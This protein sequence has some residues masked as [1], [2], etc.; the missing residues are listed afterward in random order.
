[1]A[2]NQR[3]TSIGGGIDAVTFEIMRNAFA[4]V[5]NEMA[6]VVAKT[7]YST[8]V[9]EGRDFSGTVYDADGGQ[10]SQGEFDLPAFVG[11]TQVTVPEV[12]KTMGIENIKPGDIYMVNDPFIASTHCN[13]VHMVKPVF[14]KGERVGFVASCAHW[15]D[16]GGSVPGSLNCNARECYEEGVRIPPILIQRDG[17]F[18]RDVLAIFWANMRGAWERQGDLNAQVAALRTGEGRV[19]ALVEKYGLETVRDCMKELQTYAEKLMRA[20]IAELKDGTYYA[21]DR[22]D[23]DLVTGEPKVIRLNL[24]IKGD[25]ATFDFS[26]SDDKALC[27]INCT[28]A[29]TNS[30]VCIGLKSI[31]PDVPMNIGIRR[32]VD[33][34]MRPDSIV[35]AQP[36]SAVSGLAATTMECVVAC[37][38]LALGQALPE[39][40]CGAPY[41]IMNTVYAGFDPRPGFQNHFINYV[42]GFGGLGAC[43]GHDGPS[44]VGSPY[45]ASTQNIPCELQERRYPVVWLRYMLKQDSGGPGKFRGGLGCD[46]LVT[47]PYTDGTLSCIGD[48]E[49]FGPPGVFGGEPGGRAGLI[50]NE[51]TENERNIGIFAANHPVQAH[52]L[53][54]YWSAGG[55]G[56]G[57]PL[58]RD[59]QMVLD[60]VINDYISIQGARDDYGV[61]V[62][63]IDKRRLVYEID[64]KETKALREKMRK[65]RNG[66]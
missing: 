5:C 55:G 20:H 2:V 17:E 41:S 63:E 7:A 29:A 15:S 8:P 23:Q 49:R 61:A 45:T 22:V 11:V 44:V 28:S 14:W 39:K 16:V 33:I 38:E 64:E 30:A 53:A 43:V 59:P 31:F 42:W 13:D 66:K 58:E 24:I 57:D 62:K 48:R 25:Q 6:L 34:Q 35:W 65:S 10:V 52:E 4:G 37:T 40:A 56:Y 1:M 18:N 12:I 26:E 9:N 46:Q 19:I 21:E 54:H 27:G 36:P 60:D 51:G 50:L 3:D 32:A 47:F